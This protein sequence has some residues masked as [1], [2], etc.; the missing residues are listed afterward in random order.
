MKTKLNPTY[1]NWKEESDFATHKMNEIIAKDTK[2][3]LESLSDIVAKIRKLNYG[4]CYSSY[5]MVLNSDKILDKIT[6]KFHLDPYPY[7]GISVVHDK[8]KFTEPLL[9]FKESLF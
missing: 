7:G 8:I 9:L 3:L 2:I 1:E 6:I 5:L 4:T